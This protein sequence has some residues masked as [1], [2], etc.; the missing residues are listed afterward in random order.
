MHEIDNKQE[1]RLFEENRLAIGIETLRIMSLVLAVVCLTS[2]LL[3]LPGDFTPRM[4]LSGM[5]QGHLLRLVGLLTGIIFWAKVEPKKSRTRMQLIRL[6]SLALLLVWILLIGL[7]ASSA[8][9]VLDHDQGSGAVF[10]MG[11]AVLLITMIFYAGNTFFLTPIFLAFTSLGAL[12]LTFLFIKENRTELI[13]FTNYFVAS[14]ILGISVYLHRKR[15]DSSIFMYQIRIDALLSRA[16]QSERL[17]R[18]SARLKSRFFSMVGHDLRQPLVGMDLYLQ[19]LQRQALAAPNLISLDILK[20]L[21]NCL[22]SLEAGV[23]GIQKVAT[24]NQ[25]GRKVELKEIPPIELV[26][27]LRAIFSPLSASRSIRLRLRVP[28]DKRI[29]LVSDADLLVE[30]LGNLISNA[31]K[32]RKEGERSSWVF[33]GVAIEKDVAGKTQAR[34]DVVDNGIGIEAKHMASIFDEY[35]QVSRSAKDGSEGF[36]LGLAIV[37]ELC[38]ELAGHSIRARS[39]FGRGSKFSIYVPISPK[40]SMSSSDHA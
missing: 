17:E 18:E 25:V 30:I 22:R 10:R 15:L 1:A 2:F 23:A 31:L 36:G 34:I 39:I 24:Q 33:L 35:F 19:A 28:R 32:F 26:E 14:H 12:V 40:N 3:L 7:I 13:S 11:I 37:K 8:S 38:S 4:L 9:L 21:S 6:H 29:L 16:I 20:G 5:D 27:R